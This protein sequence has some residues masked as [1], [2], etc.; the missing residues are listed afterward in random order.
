[1]FHYIH[2]LLAFLQIGAEQAANRDFVTFF[3]RNLCAA[4]LNL[5]IKAVRQAGKQCGETQHKAV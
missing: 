5:N 4:T 2:Q 3:H 1:M